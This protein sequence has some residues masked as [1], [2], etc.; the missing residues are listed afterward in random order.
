MLRFILASTALAATPAALA[1]EVTD[2]LLLRGDQQLWIALDG[3]PDR[4]RVEA[5]A[6]ALRLSLAGFQPAQARTIAPASNTAVDAISIVPADMGA[7]ILI[8][9]AFDLASAEL[10]QGGVLIDFTPGR[11]SAMA[12]ASEPGGTASRLETGEREDRAAG[13]TGLTRGSGQTA[14]LTD[15]PAQPV[16]DAPP[17]AAEPQ[18]MRPASAAPERLSAA[19]TH[20]PAADAAQ[21]Q[22]IEPSQAAAPDPDVP[23]PCDASAARVASSPWD[24]DALTVH[25]DCLVEIGQVNNGAGLYER[26]LAFEP[27]HFQAA[28]GLARIRERQGR[29]GEAARLYEAAANSALTDGQALAARQA[30]DRLRDEN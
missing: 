28:L 20:E 5:R 26:V 27:S 9:G 24:L 13:A 19:S 14:Q 23:G 17:T 11:Y 12:A 7:D 8:E 29:R 21:P 22:R 25:A 2:V 3:E 16:D 30:A 18:A 10:R 4:L 1:D 6:G 15:A